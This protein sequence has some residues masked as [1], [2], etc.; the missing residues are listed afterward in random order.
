[1][2]LSAGGRTVRPT[3]GV[4]L[5]CRCV[6]TPAVTPTVVL[7]MLVMTYLSVR[8]GQVGKPGRDRGQASDGC[9]CAGSYTVTPPSRSHAATSSTGPTDRPKDINPSVRL[10]ESQTR[11]MTSAISSLAYGTGTGDVAGA[12]GR[13]GA[14]GQAAFGAAHEVRG[15]LPQCVWAL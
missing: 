7:V 4:T 2:R 14:E 10:T 3:T 5:V 8:S 6:S 12:V 11:P 13:A 15:Q 1:V 9:L